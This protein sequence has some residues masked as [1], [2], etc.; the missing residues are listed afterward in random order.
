MG[1]VIRAPMLVP[2]DLDTGKEGESGLIEVGKSIKCGSYFARSYSYQ[3][4]WMTTPVTAIYDY[5]EDAVEGTSSCKVKTGNS[6]YTC[7]GF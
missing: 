3:D 7:R 2:V 1:P 4:W 5:E 6:V